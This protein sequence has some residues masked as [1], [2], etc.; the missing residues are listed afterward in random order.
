M[1]MNDFYQYNKIP[2]DFVYTGKMMFGVIDL[3]N[4][5]YFPPGKPKEFPERWL[6]QYV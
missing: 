3:I 2:L 6:G 1:F 5:N 4:K